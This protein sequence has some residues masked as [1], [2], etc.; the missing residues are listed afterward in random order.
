VPA[1]VNEKFRHYF[2]AALGYRARRM[3]FCFSHGRRAGRPRRGRQPP[4]GYP[5]ARLDTER[6][7]I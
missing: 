4:R 2:P 5:L 1:L 6:G 3:G 7:E